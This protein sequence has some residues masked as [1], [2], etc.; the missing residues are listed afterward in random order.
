MT[1]AGTLFV[2]VLA[3]AAPL[4]F[5]VASVRQ[6]RLEDRI[7]TVA[8][9]PGGRF[10]ARGY[11]L[12]L[13]IQRAYGVMDWNIQGGPSWIR[14]DRFDVV[15]T[16]AVEGNLTETQLQPMLRK[17]L[18]D[19]FRLAVHRSS[20]QIAGQALVVAR[21]GLR[22]AKPSTVNECRD[23]FQFDGNGVEAKGITMSDFAAWVGGKLG[24]IAV[25]HTG[26]DGRYDLRATWRFDPD[27]TSSSD[28]REEFRSL[29]VDAL[30]DQLGLKIVRRKIRIETIVIDQ[31]DRLSD[32]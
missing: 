31:V 30:E 29:V 23:S 6:N 12:A 25:D 21:G 24:W 19:R 11:T 4:E 3:Q 18:V 16:A 32:N 2:S 9:G 22:G 1:I 20:R 8:A 15:A 28:P 26:L 7:V 13:L 10:A 27:R 17:M 14:S 5:E